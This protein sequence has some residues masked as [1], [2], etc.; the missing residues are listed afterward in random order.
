MGLI[1]RASGVTTG[2]ARWIRLGILEGKSTGE[3]IELD[4]WGTTPND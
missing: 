1:Q 3:S 2:T 4:S